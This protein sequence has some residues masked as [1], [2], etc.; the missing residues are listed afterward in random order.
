MKKVNRRTYSILALI[1]AIVVLSTI[2]LFRLASD[3]EA[4]ATFPTNTNIFRDGQL[5]VG[6]VLDRN[7]VPLA[8]PVERRMRYN[9]DV[10]IRRAT[11]HIMG[12]RAGNIGTGILNAYAGTLIGYNFFTGVYSLGGEGNTIRLTIDADLNT[13]AYGALNG[14]HGAVVVMN[15]ETG[16]ILASVSAPTFDPQNPPQITPGDPAF[17]GVFINRVLSSAFVP[18]SIFKIVTA[19]AALDTFPDAWNREYLCTGYVTVA[20]HRVTCTGNH[21]RINLLQAM[22]HS[23]NPYFAQ[24]ALDLGGPLLRRYTEQFG[25][26]DSI[27]VDGL[28]SGAGNFV[29]GADGSAALA[30]SGAGQ[31][32]NLVNPLSMTR[33]LGAIARG[34]VPIEPRLIAGIDRGLPTLFGQDPV[35]GERILPTGVANTLSNLLRET[36]IGYYGGAFGTLLVAGKTGTAE[37]GQGRTPHAWFAGFLDDPRNPLAFVVLVEH[38]GGGLAAAGSVANTVLQAAVR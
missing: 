7:D 35:E 25:L 18:G 17:D 22:G 21:G 31:G 6:A 19:G 27:D 38:G 13:V 30:W 32:E 26:L 3:G 34:G 11:L 4:W 36:A 1:L 28:P 8:H 15:Y 23:C 20:G 16:E 12:D 9:D 14:R 10:T 24:L 29:A 5:S 33:L 2:F 37:V